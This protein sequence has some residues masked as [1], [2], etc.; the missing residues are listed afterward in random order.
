MS[1]PPLTQQLISFNG[2]INIGFMDSDSHSHEHMLRSFCDFVMYLQEIGS[3]K[4]LVAE[5]VIVKVF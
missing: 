5:V 4:S 2:R 1:E 3:L